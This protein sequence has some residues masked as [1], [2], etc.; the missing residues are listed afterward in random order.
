M[1]RNKLIGKTIK[2]IKKV[3]PYE[4]E[5]YAGE[6]TDD[7]AL[8]LIM[9]DGSTFRIFGKWNSYTGDSL[10]EYPERVLVKELSKDDR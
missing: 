1:D 2:D 8:D 5:Y 4:D 3:S 10:D 9:T 7:E 6:F